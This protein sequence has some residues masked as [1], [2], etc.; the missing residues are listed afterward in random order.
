MST[1][2]VSAEVTEA[3]AENVGDA[4]EE[5]VEMVEVVRNNPVLLTIAGAV[6]LTAGAVGGYFLARKLLRNE[7]EER[8]EEQ[9]AETKEFYA[10][11]YKTTVDGEPLTP[12]EILEQN[13]PE[14]LAALRAYQ[15]TPKV[16]E[17]PAET[18]EELLEHP[19]D[20]E[21]DERQARITEARI[22]SVSLEK[23][24]DPA[25]GVHPIEVEK[26]E[27][28]ESVNVFVDR[29]FDYAEE[30]KLRT[31][32]RPYVIT[33]D[34]YFGA[35]H[36]EYD[37]IQLTYFEKDGTL[38]DEHDKPIDDVDGTIGDESL[39]RFGHGSKDNKIVYVRNEKLECEYE[40]VL[41]DQSY[42]EALGLGPEPNELRHSDQ[43]DRRRAFRQGDG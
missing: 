34:E 11:V 19:G 22:H 39:A 27:P 23:E 42:L 12:Q 6:G 16:V 38:V 24:A 18:E 29:N 35:E 30:K 1:E 8:L 31:K 40:V 26:P 25:K 21:M 13:D 3:V 32:D 4:V 7:Y 10:G 14:A 9:I 37:T 33:H 5:M 20:D 28:S 43:R 36:E 2:T 17:T 15:G 41:S